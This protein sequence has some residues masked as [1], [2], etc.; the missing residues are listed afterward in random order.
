MNQ[1]LLTKKCKTC[2]TEFTLDNFNKGQ[3][4]YKK[5]NICKQ[6]D[7]EARVERYKNYSNERKQELQRRNRVNHYKAT[8]NLPQY[9][10]EKLA[11]NRVGQCQICSKVT[12][13]VVDHCHNTDIVRGMLCHSCNKMLGHSFD[14]PE[15]LLKAAKY[16]KDNVMIS[17]DEILNVIDT[18]EEAE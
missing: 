10:A 2:N 13:L 9:V 14:N 11:N 7:S 4:K 18:P 6:C 16:L 15:V 17:H 3:G 8:Y 12:N 5:A 1:N